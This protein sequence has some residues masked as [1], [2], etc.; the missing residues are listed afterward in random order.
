MADLINSKLW[1]TKPRII[2]GVMTGTSLDSI[3]IAFVK[4]KID[5]KGQHSFD[6]IAGREYNLPTDYK[7]KVL[8]LINNKNRISDYSLFQVVYSKLVADAIKQ[9]I[10]EFEIKQ[11][12]DAIS[13][14]GQTLW[15][16]PKKSKLFKMELSH[17]YQAVSAT[18]LATLLEIPVMYDFR[19]NDIA[20][21]GNGA[22]LLPIFDYNFLKS[23][24]KDIIALNIGGIAN[25]TYI[26]KASSDERIVAFDTGAGNMLIDEAMAYYFKKNYDAN[27]AIAKSGK[28]NEDLLDFLLDDAY[29]KLSPPKSTGREKFGSEYFAEL[30]EK[31]KLY[32]C[33]NADLINTLTH[34][35]AR[36]IADAILKIAKKGATIY[37]SGGGRKNKELLYILRDY[38]VKY[39]VKTIDEIGINGDLKE[40][41]GFAYIAWRS[42]GGM[43]GN[44]PSAT[45]A[46][47]KLRLGALAL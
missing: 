36:T 42:I 46:N 39:E 7:K 44:L 25:L 38:L 12:I 35:T 27:G 2:C 37:V 34:F 11:D 30:L 31:Q 5:E 47:K 4:F 21:G 22:P 8:R 45:G 43:Y 6:F 3:D 23:K 13:V 32:K 10:S 9:A 16:E 1:F 26:P 41:I 28:L 20:S 18:T 40:A 29:F 14:H 15:H 19:A 33:S 17:T 24:D